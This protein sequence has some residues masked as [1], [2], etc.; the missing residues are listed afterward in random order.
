MA[1]IALTTAKAARDRAERLGTTKNITA[2]DLENARAAAQK[3]EIDLKAA[4]LALDKRTITA[5]FAGVIG[6]TD[7]SVGDLVTTAKPITTLDDMTTLTVSFDVAER[8]AGLVAIGQ[9]VDA[10]ERRPASA[11]RSRAGSSPSTTASTP[12]R[13]R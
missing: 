8:V 1:E 6:L 7:L 4:K 11:A 10:P 5:P 13:A 9:E 2:V 12:R 3:A